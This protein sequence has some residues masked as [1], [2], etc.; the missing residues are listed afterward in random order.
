VIQDIAVDRQGNVYLADLTNR[1]VRK[2]DTQG[3]VSTL[4][5]D[6]WIKIAD[7]EIHPNGIAV[8]KSGEI[9]VSDSGSSKIRKID[10]NQKVTTFAGTGEFR[11]FGDGGPAIQAGIRS[12]GGL[13]F[14]P[15]GELYIAEETSH[16][17]RKINKEGN[18]ILVAG[19]GIAGYGGDSGPATQAQLKSPYRMAFDKEGN[20]Y[21]SDRDNNRIRKI[22]PLGII[23]TVAGNSNIGWLQDGMEVRITVH[24]SP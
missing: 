8:N 9:F 11:D 6:T 12:P 17:I 20:L 7:E 24:N 4:A 14:S 2:V 23:S 16:R 5:S 10:R 1:K 3:V 22:D 15:D 13:A 19:T 21:F 18:I